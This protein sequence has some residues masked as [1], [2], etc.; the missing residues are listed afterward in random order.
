MKS[1]LNRLS[2]KGFK[3]LNLFTVQQ[4]QVHKLCIQL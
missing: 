3:L 4:K 1:H 2:E